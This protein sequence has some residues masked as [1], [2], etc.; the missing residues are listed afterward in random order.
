M[1]E[2]FAAELVEEKIA[3]HM[4]SYV[5]LEK[6]PVIRAVPL[7][8]KKYFLMLGANLS[9]RSITAVYSIWNFFVFPKEYNQNTLTVSEFSQVPTPC[10]FVPVLTKTKWFLDL[11]PSFPRIIFSEIF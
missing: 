9:S 2:Q 3:R 1:K 5:R 7:E 6:N 4:N 10:S 8:I 11:P